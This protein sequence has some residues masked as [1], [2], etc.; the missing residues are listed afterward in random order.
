MRRITE[1][2]VAAAGFPLLLAARSSGSSGS[3][4][5]GGGGGAATS[6]AAGGGGTLVVWADNSANTAK[7]IE[8]L[9]STFLND[10]VMTTA[11]QDGMY[12]IDP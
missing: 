10:E 4:T 9:A 1:V 8:P 11:F 2:G 5:G 12:E 3:S 6:S 7:A